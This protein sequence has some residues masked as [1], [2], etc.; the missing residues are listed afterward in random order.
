MQTQNIFWI[1]FYALYRDMGYLYIFEP[2]L[3]RDS[4]HIDFHF[5]NHFEY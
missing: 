4:A 5:N 2:L 1:Q 3:I